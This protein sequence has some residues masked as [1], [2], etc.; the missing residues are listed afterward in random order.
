MSRVW[1]GASEIATK[2]N[3]RK[4]ALENHTAK[5]TSEAI[6]GVMEGRR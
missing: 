1:T 3:R 4:R 2:Y 5:T 6:D